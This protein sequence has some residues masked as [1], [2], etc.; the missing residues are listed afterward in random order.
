MNLFLFLSVQSNDT[1]YIGPWP[2][3]LKLNNYS[4]VLAAPA[5]FNLLDSFVN[6]SSWTE[7]QTGIGSAHVTFVTPK[8]RMPIITIIGNSKSVLHMIHLIAKPYPTPPKKIHITTKIAYL[9]GALKKR[10][11][12]K[13]PVGQTRTIIKNKKKGDWLRVIFD[14][15]LKRTNLAG[16]AAV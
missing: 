9:V 7:K 3:I 11:E 8:T 14:F 13:Y 1:N 15:C 5:H 16:S 2:L 10:A 12:I 4:L 6:L